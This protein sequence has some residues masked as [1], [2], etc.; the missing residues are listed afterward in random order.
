MFRRGK[1]TSGA[2]IWSGM[3]QLAKPVNRGIAKSS[4]MTEPCIVNAWLYCSFDTSW[5]PGR[6]N[7]ARMTS[8][9]SPPTRKKTNA[10]TRYSV[11]ILL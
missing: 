1:A 3:I 7:S 5:V 11:P 6:A 4:S 10:E 2:P 8:A 9:I